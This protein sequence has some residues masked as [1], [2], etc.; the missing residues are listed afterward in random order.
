VG[1]N[2]LGTFNGNLLTLSF[3]ARAVNVYSTGMINVNYKFA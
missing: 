2:G 3:S 1:L